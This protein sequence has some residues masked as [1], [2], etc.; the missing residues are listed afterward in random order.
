MGTTPRFFSESC[1]STSSDQ[2][3][4]LVEGWEESQFDSGSFDLDTLVLR[5]GFFV[6]PEGPLDQAHGGRCPSMDEY[7][8]WLD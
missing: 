4:V 1:P 7:D 2:E 6:A 8:E 3:D 5:D